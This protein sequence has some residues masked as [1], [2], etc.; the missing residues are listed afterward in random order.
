MV[1]P[2]LPWVAPEAARARAIR[3]RDEA[4]FRFAPGTAGVTRNV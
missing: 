1:E 3:T 4:L 2:E